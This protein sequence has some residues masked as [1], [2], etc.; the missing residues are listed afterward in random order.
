MLENLET[1]QLNGKKIETEYKKIKLLPNIMSI[2]LTKLSI[3][4]GSKYDQ[5]KKKY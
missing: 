2:I 4:W 5:L 1:F 3:N